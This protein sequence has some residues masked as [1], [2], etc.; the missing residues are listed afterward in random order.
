MIEQILNGNL[1]KEIVKNYL[2]SLFEP[3]PV[4]L[5]RPNETEVN[6]VDKAINV[7]TGYKAAVFGLGPVNRSSFLAACYDA[8]HDARIEHL[9][10]GYGTK[11]RNTT[12]ISHLHHVVGGEHSVTP[13]QRMLDEIRKQMTEVCKGEVIFFHNHPKWFLNVLMDNLPLAS[14]QDRDTASNLKFNLF[15]FL[16]TV[17]GNGDV[18]CYVGENGFVK[19][20]VLPP[21]DK[22]IELYHQANARKTYQS[23]SS[24]N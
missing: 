15:Q 16:K 7:A 18:R 13:T 5:S 12:K 11:Y 2:L 19:E 17:F 22:L 9:I 4:N 20:F 8:T 21:F 10:V 24:M 14:S 3:N 1:G 23:L 6:R